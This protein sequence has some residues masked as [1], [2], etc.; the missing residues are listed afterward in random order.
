MP[1]LN[2]IADFAP[3]MTAWRRHLHQHPELSFACHKTAAFVAER[4]RAFGVDE[5]HEGIATTG[6]VAIIEGQGGAPGEGPTI[7]LRADMDALPIAETTGAEHASTVPGV[8]HACGHDGHTTML[9]GAAKYL[10]ETRRFRGRVALIF[11][12][13]EEDG[14][15][16]NVMVQEGILDRFGIG[17]V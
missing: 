5:I 14:G 3:E 17:D 15:G 8:M 10:A 12:P 11:Q 9:L 16:G 6:I 2:R 13:A 4:L 7:G 1:V